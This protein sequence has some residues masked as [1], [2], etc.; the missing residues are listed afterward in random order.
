MT[1]AKRLDHSFPILRSVKN[2]V[3][4]T[5]KKKNPLLLESNEIFELMGWSALPDSVKLTVAI[6]M[7]GFRDEICG[8]FTTS[9]PKV[10]TRRKRIH[11]WV[12]S[13]LDGLSTEQDV[14][15]ALKVSYLN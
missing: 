9:D 2:D 7:I 5:P 13:F 3:T 15:E 12:N 14:N 1:T 11:Y 8:L 4:T 6:D 10:L